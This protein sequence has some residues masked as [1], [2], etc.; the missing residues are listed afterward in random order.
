MFVVSFELHYLYALVLIICHNGNTLM[1][2]ID[3]GGDAIL[4][5]RISSCNNL[6]RNKQ[7]SKSAG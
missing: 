7:Y 4:N 6:E 3:V 1:S 2:D 5:H